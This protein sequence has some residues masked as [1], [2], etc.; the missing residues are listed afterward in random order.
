VSANAPASARPATVKPRVLCVDDE[1]QVLEGLTLNLRRRFEVHTAPGG[2]EGLKLIETAT[3]PF[4]VIISDM[5]MPVMTGAV[6]LSQVRQRWPDTV[7]MLLTGHSEIDAAIMAVN[8]GQIFRFLAKPCPPDKLVLAVEAAAEQYR[9]VTAERVLL[10]QTL[11]GSIKALT[12]ILSLQS[13]LAFGRAQR[14]KGHVAA[15]A[16]HQGIRMGDSARWPLEVAA[17]LYPIGTVTLPPETVEKLHDGRPLSLPEQAMVKRLPAVTEQLLANIPRLEPVREIM[18][19]LD[20]RYDGEG[21]TRKEAA[22]PVGARM[23]RLV[24]DYDALETQ[25]MSRGVA[26]DT[27]RSRKGAYDPE[28]LAAFATLLGTQEQQATVEEL[29]LALLQPGMVFLEDVRSGNGNLLIARGHEITASLLERIRN[30]SRNG[31]VK[32][33]LRVKVPPK[34]V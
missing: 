30:F 13:P 4:A 19:F 22:L 29:G 16:E 11:R 14:A 9:L 26:F 28:L 10:E 3:T 20:T 25:G 33:P 8:E 15:L 27:L 1:P 12:D 18:A 17:M 21:G 7:R 32:E 5:R 34:K 6:F 24:L 23:L 31:G 2:P